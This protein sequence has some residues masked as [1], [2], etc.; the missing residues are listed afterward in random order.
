[1]KKF[2]LGFVACVIAL[3]NAVAFEESF[4]VNVMTNNHLYFTTTASNRIITGL[5]FIC[6]NTM[7]VSLYD[8]STNLNTY[9][10]AAYVVSQ[11]YTTNIVRT[12]T[13]TL[14]FVQSV[15]NAGV[16]TTSLSI[17]AG[18]QVLPVL[19]SVAGAPNI[20]TTVSGLNI[21]ITR[22]LASVGTATNGTLTVISRD[23]N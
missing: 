1:M 6:T 5:R 11:Q 9:T 20:V 8:S 23:G 19:L 17:S 16:F 10:N 7:S 15:T 22:G 21:R 2:F 12:Y 13:N 4:T 18:T 3:L 14:G